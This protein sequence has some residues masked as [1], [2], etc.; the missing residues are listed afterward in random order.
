M[1]FQNVQHRIEPK[2][3]I[4]SQSNLSDVGRYIGEAGVQQFNAA[5]PGS[6][7]ASSLFRIP[8]ISG[9]G[10]HAQQ[11]MYERLPR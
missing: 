6:G 7:I 5:I 1:L 4:R 8:Q 9:V 3:R 2:T 11:R 10:F